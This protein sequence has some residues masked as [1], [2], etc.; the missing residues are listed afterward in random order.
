MAQEMERFCA[1]VPK[2]IME[3]NLLRQ[4][5][6]R[7]QFLIYLPVKKGTREMRSADHTGL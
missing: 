6:T 1:G 4:Y 5:Q 3:H 7:T 2:T